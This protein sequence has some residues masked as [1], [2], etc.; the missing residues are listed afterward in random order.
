MLLDLKLLKISRLEVLRLV[1]ANFRTTL[2]PVV[3]LTVS[4]EEQTL[5]NSYSLHGMRDI[6]KPLDCTGLP[7]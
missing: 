3:I 5:I 4:K 7:K 2:L 1:R 6:R